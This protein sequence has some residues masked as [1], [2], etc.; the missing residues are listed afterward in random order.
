MV[1]SA[2]RAWTARTE[3][4][5]DKMSAARRKG[6]WLGGAPVLGLHDERVDQQARSALPRSSLQPAYAGCSVAHVLYLGQVRHKGVVYP[7]EQPP[8]VEQELWSRVQ[9]QLNLG[10]RTGAAHHKIDA[11]LLSFLYCAQCGERMG[12]DSSMC[13]PRSSS[14]HLKKILGFPP[15]TKRELLPSAVSALGPTRLYV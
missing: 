11:L 2:E 9:E 6:K 3:R 12:L 15:L 4:T 8:L 7:G 14:D 5:R 10:A 1:S 13:F